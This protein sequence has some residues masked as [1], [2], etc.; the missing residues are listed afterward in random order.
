V[1]F[2]FSGANEANSV[3]RSED[4]WPKGHQIGNVEMTSLLDGQVPLFGW[5]PVAPSRYGNLLAYG[6]ARINCDVVVPAGSAA[7]SCHSAS[8]CRRKSSR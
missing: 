5:S 2:R 1:N 8:A 6:H 4:R 3:T 7:A